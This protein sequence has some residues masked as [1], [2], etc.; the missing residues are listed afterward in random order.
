[1]IQISLKF[2]AMDEMANK[3]A[4]IQITFSHIA[5]PNWMEYEIIDISCLYWEL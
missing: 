2:A 3:P 1:M 4:S 5:R